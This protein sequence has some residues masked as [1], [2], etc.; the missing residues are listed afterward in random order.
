MATKR[1][2]SKREK[3]KAWDIAITTNKKLTNYKKAGGS[4]KRPVIIT[5]TK[6][7]SVIRVMGISKTNK[8]KLGKQRT[9]LK[10]TKGLKKR[11][12]ADKQVFSTVYT[13]K[14]EQKRNP[15]IKKKPIDL[16][17]RNIIS[18]KVGK[19]GRHD[20]KEIK[21]MLNTKKKRA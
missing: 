15:S 16:S 7:V 12:A 18:G 8:S 6:P 19:V 13:T 2:Q 21:K 11:S 20:K 9:E 5:N 14:T 4:D 10:D 3:P 17:D 1:K